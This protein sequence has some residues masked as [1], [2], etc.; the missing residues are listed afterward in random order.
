M[1]KKA[2]LGALF[3]MVFQVAGSAAKTQTLK[4]LET[5]CDKACAV[6]QLDMRL[7]HLFNTCCRFSLHYVLDA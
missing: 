2:L 6:K 4:R 7:G 1:L 3:F 5:S